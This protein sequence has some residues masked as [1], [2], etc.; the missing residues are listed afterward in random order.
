M[1]STSF[2]HCESVKT[3]QKRLGHSSAAITLDTYAHLWP[4]ADDRTREAIEQ[5]F[6]AAEIDGAA[7]TVR[8]REDRRDV[9]AGQIGWACTQRRYI[10]KRSTDHT[11]HALAGR[12]SL[13]DSRPPTRAELGR[14]GQGVAPR[15]PPPRATTR[16][17]GGRAT[18]DPRQSRRGLP[19][20]RRVAG[21]RQVDGTPHQ[22]PARKIIRGHLRAF[23]HRDPKGR[24]ASTV[25]CPVRDDRRATVVETVVGML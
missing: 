15:R 13:R 20:G 7:D 24:T 19:P 14:G 23:D 2:R 21:L 4:D 25:V 18:R 8:T 22:P 6:T 5:A 17:P 16:R 10:S 11:R 1:L 9:R 3:V 12:A